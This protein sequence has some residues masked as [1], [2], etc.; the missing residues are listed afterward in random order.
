MTPFKV[1]C[2]QSEAE[3][4]LAAGAGAAF[5]GLVG[6]MPSGPGPIDDARIRAIAAAAPAGIVPVLLTARRDAAEIVDHVRATGVAAVQIVRPVPAAVRLAVR[7]ALPGV[8]IL[9]V[10]HVEGPGVVAAAVAAAEG[11]D[12]VL[13]DSGRPGA[14]VAELGGTGRVHDWTV[15]ARVVRAVGVPVLLAGGLGPANAAAAL[16]AVAP[17]GLDV[18]SGLRDPEGALLPERL[19]AF[20]RALA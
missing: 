20:A 19:D 13:L 10:V 6:A 11:A 1:C 4:A 7:G 14:A 8:E 15:S 12:Y 3:M 5:G 18:C 16:R 17:W 9:Q 2:I